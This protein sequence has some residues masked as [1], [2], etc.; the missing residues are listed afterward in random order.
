MQSKP[1]MPVNAGTGPPGASPKQKTKKSILSK[2]KDCRDIE[3]CHNDIGPTGAKKHV[4]IDLGEQA[5]LTGCGLFEGK[6]CFCP[7]L[8]S[9]VIFEP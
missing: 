1:A 2:P 4:R 3:G 8:L 9:L 6:L 7:K 5:V